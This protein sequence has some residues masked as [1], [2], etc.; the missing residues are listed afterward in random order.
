MQSIQLRNK[1][2]YSLCF[3]DRIIYSSFQL[4]RIG[5]CLTGS[6]L[7]A[8][9]PLGLISVEKFLGGYCPPSHINNGY[10]IYD[11]ERQLFLHFVKL[12]LFRLQHR[13]TNDRHIPSDYRCDIRCKQEHLLE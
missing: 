10:P 1:Y 6:C 3:G 2:Q 4:Y 7:S 11:G 8:I 9:S 13:L 12:S 5:L